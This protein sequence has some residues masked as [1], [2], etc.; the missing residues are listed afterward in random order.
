MRAAVLAFSLLLTP[1]A[2]CDEEDAGA[3]PRGNAGFAVDLYGQVRAEKGNLFLSPYSISTAL[4]MTWAGARANT[5]KEMAATLHFRLPQEA[6]HPAM[7]ALMKDLNGRT[8]TQRS[9]DQGRKQLELCVANSLWSQKGYPFRQEYFDLVTR[10]YEAGL[11]E[12]DFA[13][14]TEGARKTINAWVEGKTN[15]RIKD[16]IP[17]GM[18]TPDNVLVLT[19]AIYFK[20]AWAEP[21]RKEA[22]IDEEFHLADGSTIKTPIMHRQHAY[23]YF[24]EGTFEVVDVPY[25]GGDISMTIL[26][27]KEANGLG[28]IEERLTSTTLEGWI[29]K[30]QSEQIALGLP[31]FKTTW[32]FELSETL[33]AMGMKDAFQHPAADFTGMSD[34]KELYIGFVIHK[35]FVDVNEEGT[36]AAAAT[37]VGMMKGSAPAEPVRLQIDRPFLFLIRDSKSGS[38]LFMG[39]ILDPRA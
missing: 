30:L 4:A 11:T 29:A 27:P 17:P 15:E 14:D 31:R 38:I 7:E 12:L 28:A 9:P 23:G 25:L 33:K 26:V 6:L 39:R 19:N 2:W 36:E 24:D 10:A 21:F 1:F 34:T 8:V 18:L 13:K 3:V 35:A 32:S 5:E 22:T 37:A 16:L 20:A